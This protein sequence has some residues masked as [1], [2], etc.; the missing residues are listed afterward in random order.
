MKKISLFL[1]LF[2]FSCTNDPIVYTLTATAEPAEGGQVVPEFMEYGEG[3]NA[4]VVA[5]PSDEYVLES[6]SGDA[7]GNANTIVITMD[8]NK[9]VT[10]NF[11][12]KKY[13]LTIKIEGE[14]EVKQE[15]IK[16]GTVTDYNS[17]TIVKLTAEPEE[18]WEFV[19]WRGD[20]TGNENPTQITI[21]EPK[22]VVAEFIKKKYPL[23]IEIEGE[24][25]V[26]QK[27]I[28]QGVSTDY[29]S[30]TVLE[31]T[32]LSDDG[33]EFV[34]W[35]EDLSGS[36][37]PQ[38]I[39]IDGPKT[40]KAVFTESKVYVP[41]DNFE[42]HLIDIGVDDILDDYVL[43]KS[44]DTLK[45][46]QYM[47]DI[48][49]P[50]FLTP[51]QENLTIKSLRGIDSFTSLET[52]IIWH[53]RFESVDLNKLT[54]LK[55]LSFDLG[56]LKTID[57]SNNSKLGILNLRWNEL[58]NLNVS[59]LPELYYLNFRDNHVSSIDLSNN[60]DL[61][62]LLAFGNNLSEIDLSNNNSL[63]VVYLNKYGL[64]VG[65]SEFYDEI[66]NNSIN[67]LITPS[68][69]NIITLRLTGSLIEEMDMKSFE[70]L[71]NF[72]LSN[73]QTSSIN[74]L[75]LISKLNSLNVNNTNLNE[76]VG[77]SGSSISFAGTKV[78]KFDATL[79]TPDGN[80]DLII[81]VVHSSQKSET[82]LECLQLTREQIDAMGSYNIDLPAR[83]KISL[84]CFNNTTQQ[85][86][87]IGIWTLT[88]EQWVGSGTW[89]EGQARGCWKSGDDGS[90]DQYIFTESSVTKKVWECHQ[91]GDL[92]VDLV[93][94]GP[95]SWS[96]QGNGNYQWGGQTTQVTFENNS[97]IMK[98]PFDDGNIL[99]TWT[100]N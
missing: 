75:N 18:E 87:I 39:T 72:D 86:P 33:W 96:N 23:T 94:Y 2:L 22:T 26:D 19:R 29:N 97:T 98:L 85:D 70:K 79:M 25:T 43:Q 78:E 37:N 58:R 67:N 88:N 61:D 13:P 83:T 56:K 60:L 41:D 28:K 8:K 34:E 91:D 76:L 7:S 24:G 55:H 54:E 47:N 90:P 6:W 17:G 31:L 71:V 51:D 100:K 74:N 62:N 92:A 35:K 15:V 44:I 5:T 11:I 36:E 64:K 9:E 69:N 95:I 50:E 89:P 63:R 93:T 84:N 53:G 59:N 45:S 4:Y 46:I 99:Q 48:S 42:Q 30:G 80:G 12:K 57:L 16:Q 10:A 40:V 49:H 82:P 52:L 81:D 66:S 38:Q 77:Y 32:A 21:D 1:L 20:I 14:G 68:D 73:S 3:D 65:Y 27:I